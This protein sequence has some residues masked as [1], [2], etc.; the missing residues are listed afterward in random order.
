MKLHMVCGLA[1]AVAS[2]SSLSGCIAEETAD[3]EDEA[4]ASSEAAL[5]VFQWSAPV[6]I[7]GPRTDDAVALGAYR[8]NAHMVY[9]KQGGSDLYHAVYDGASWSTAVPIPGQKSKN[10]PALASMGGKADSVLHMVHQGETS[11]DLWWSIYNGSSWTANS[12]IAMSSTQAPIMATYGVGLHLFGTNAHT[13]CAFGTS[14]STTEVLWEST[15]NGLTWSAP[16]EIVTSAN[17]TIDGVGGSAVAVYNG[18]PVLVVRRASN[19]LWMYTYQNGIWSGGTK[20]PGQKSKS[21]PALASFG[22]YL[23]MTHLGDTSSSVWWSYWDGVG[24]T[25][26]D[27]IPNAS[28]DWAAAMAPAGSKLVQAFRQYCGNTVC[29]GAV[30]FQTFQ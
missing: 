6:E 14:C 21:A 17:R 7:A 16:Q 22:G 4:V 27:T 11:D 10:R 19:D 26:N 23:H 15:F 9:T 28:S 13:S 2:A 25:T 29:W 8:G 18:I 3:P 1:L 30:K 5:T 24:W 20:V 12:A